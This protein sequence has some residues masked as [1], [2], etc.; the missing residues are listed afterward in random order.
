MS[1]I[2]SEVVCYYDEVPS[3]WAVDT[4]RRL[5]DLW[6]QSWQNHGWTAT[7]L[8]EADVKTHS[9]YGFFRDNFRAK[10]SEYPADYTYACFMRWLCASHYAK[11]RG[12]TVVLSDYDV[13]N[14]GRRPMEIIPGNLRLMCDPPP[15]TIF[16]GVVIGGWQHFLDIAEL[17]A[18]WTPDEKD[19]NRNA[20][21]YHQDDLSMLER[22]FEH[23]TRP[24]PDW[25]TRVPGCALFGF[26]DGWKSANLV[27][28]GYEVKKTGL[29][30]KHSAIQ[31]LRPF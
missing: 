23:K 3:L 5:I 12:G 6:Q 26:G 16:M 21:C 10:P 15:P 29:W 31:Q 13:I 20:N 22:M 19:F 27:H 14:Y 28:F 30:P 2:C 9:R 25:F 24:R 1:A 17:F 4:Q 7:V 11:P 8:T 18:A